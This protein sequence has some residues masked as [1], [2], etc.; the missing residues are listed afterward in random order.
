MNDKNHKDWEGLFE[1]M[2]VDAD[3]NDEHRA[4]LREQFLDLVETAPAPASRRQSF[5]DTGRTLM[6]YK[7]PHFSAVAMLLAGLA[8]L[9]Q[10]GTPAY[11]LDQIIDNMVKARTARFEM[12]VKADG[13]PEQKMK[14]LYMEPSHFRQELGLGLVNISD[15]KVGKMIGLNPNA[16]QATV[17]NIVNMPDDVKGQQ[18]RNHFDAIRETLGKAAKNPDAKVEPLGEKGLDGRRVVGFRFF[19][20]P[21][22]MTMWA[23]PATQLPVRIEA[24]MIGPPKT[25]V[26]MSNYEFDVELDK[27]LFSLEIPKGYKVLETDVDASKPSENDLIDALKFCRDE[28]GEFPAGID[29][30]GIASFISKLLVKQG[31][32]KEGPTKEQMQSVLKVS[33]GCQF[34]L[35]LPATAHAHYAGA[36]VK[37][38]DAKQVVFWYRPEGAKKYRVVYGD[39]SVKEVEK[40]PAVDGAVKLQI[41][42]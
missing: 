6:K 11:A 18:Q 9:L 33:R 17:L 36:K 3:V 14:A 31:V 16:K 4:K 7:A 23:D 8:W 34:G 37:P 30:V 29:S 26:V 24:I 32:G 21:D 10:N 42:R 20:N 38:G 41:Q 15:W 5:R 1:Q 12:T 22:P 39:L 25:E 13:L 28:A 27:S 35:M 19:E 40:A 2:P